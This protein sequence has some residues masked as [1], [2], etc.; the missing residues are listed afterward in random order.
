MAERPLLDDLPLQWLVRIRPYPIIVPIEALLAALTSDVAV[1]M[2][3]RPTKGVWS[4]A[5]YGLACL[6]SQSICDPRRCADYPT[7]MM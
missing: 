5:L 1:K 7:W 3:C 2:W 6:D 4:S